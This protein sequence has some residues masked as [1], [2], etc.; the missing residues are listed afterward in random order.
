M[1]VVVW[2]LAIGLLIGWLL[3]A[4]QPASYSSTA[5]VLVNPTVGNP[6]APAP[7]SVRQDELTSLETEAQVARSAEVL[8]EVAAD[9]PPLTLREL[10]RGAGHHAAA[11][12]PGPRDHLH[13]GRRGR[14]PARRGRVVRRLPRQPG[15]ARRRGQRGADRLGWSRRPRASWTT[16]APPPPPPSAAREAERLFQTELAGALRNELVSLRAQR[17]SLENSEAPAGSVISPASP[18]ASAAGLTPLLM[19]RRRRVSPDSCSAA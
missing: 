5:H 13:R 1:I 2:C 15:P 17:S 19:L 16:C 11:Q 8:S 12:H 3:A 18:A 10:Q 4:A 14:G 9:N 6:F 7:A